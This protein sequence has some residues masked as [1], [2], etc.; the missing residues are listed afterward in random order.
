MLMAVDTSHISREEKMYKIFHIR[1]K[2]W[3][4]S[5]LPSSISVTWTIWTLFRLGIILL[6]FEEYLNSINSNLMPTKKGRKEMVS[7]LSK[8]V[9]WRLERGNKS[10]CSAPGW[11]GRG[12]ECFITFNWFY[13]PWQAPSSFA[14]VCGVPSSLFYSGKI[15]CSQHHRHPKLWVKNIKLSA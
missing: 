4:T 2:I 1:Q 13:K 7:R 11:M 5:T 6:K 15:Y 12:Q 3:Y 8:F 10:V 14:P 9:F